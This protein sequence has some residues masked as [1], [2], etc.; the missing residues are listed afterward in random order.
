MADSVVFQTF[1]LDVGSSL[2]P[3]ILCEERTAGH[4]DGS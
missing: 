4:L 3:E 1:S 2:V